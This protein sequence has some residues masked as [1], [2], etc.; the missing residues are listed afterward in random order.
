MSGFFVD[1]KLIQLTT[2]S[3]SKLFMGLSIIRCG[4]SK[5]A[6]ARCQSV[7]TI[8]RRIKKTVI[9]FFAPGAV[10]SNEILFAICQ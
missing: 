4:L 6:Y 9:A 2:D 7:K 8:A 3:V 1:I 10:K 5:K